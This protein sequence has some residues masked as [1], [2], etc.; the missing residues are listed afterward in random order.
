MLSLRRLSGNVGQRSYHCMSE[1]VLGVV[2]VAMWEGLAAGTFP[3]G[4]EARTNPLGIAQTVF[5]INAATHRPTRGS[6]Q[7]SEGQGESTRCESVPIPP[8]RLRAQH[9]FRLI[10][11]GNRSRKTLIG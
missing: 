4:L 7:F 5:V 6:D 8:D 9:T 1:F 11:K 3:G 2:K 10:T